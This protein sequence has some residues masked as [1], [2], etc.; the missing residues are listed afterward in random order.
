[1]RVW[2]DETECDFHPDSVAQ[3]IEY[4]AEVAERQGRLIIDV[5]VDGASWTES[6][7]EQSRQLAAPAEE[8]RMLSSDPVELVRHTWSDAA[9]ALA[10][11]D[12]RQR[13]AAHMIQADRNTEAME[14]LSE[15]ID[16]WGSVQKAVSLGSQA[17]AID[18]DQESIE[19]TPVTEYVERLGQ[20]L[21]TLRD[22]LQQE[23]PIGVSDTL[24]Y[25]LPQ[26]IAD[27]RELLSHLHD[28]AE[29]RDEEA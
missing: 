11:A 4:G 21:R 22:A 19:G 28:R 25:D 26:T 12:A 1:M 13:E 29:R 8:V 15:V 7:I 6:Q 18:L 2:L 9:E 17:L 24:L 10:E 14:Q 16:V 27:W 3:A 5:Q 20:Q 23:D